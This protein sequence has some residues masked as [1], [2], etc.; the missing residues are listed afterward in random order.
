MAG[1]ELDRLNTAGKDS[2]F[3]RKRDLGRATAVERLGG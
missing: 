1:G 2:T 3:I